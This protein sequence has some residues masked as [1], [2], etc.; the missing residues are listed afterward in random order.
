MGTTTVYGLRYPER[1]DSPD[2]PTQLHNLAT[3]VETALS[4]LIPDSGTLSNTLGVTAATGFSLVKS[5]YRTIGKKMWLSLQLSRTGTAITASA[6]GNISD[7]D[8]ATITDVSHRPAIN[9][10]GTFRSTLTGGA[11]QVE[12]TT[13]V[14]TIVDAHSGGSISTGDNVYAFAAYTIA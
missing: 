12:P 4:G 14:V 5:Q 9:W 3:D 1:T 11:C 6:A 2:G 8:I 7:T 13:G 10:F